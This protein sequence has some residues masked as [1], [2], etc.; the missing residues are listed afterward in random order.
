MGVPAG[1]LRLTAVEI[2]AMILHLPTVKAGAFMNG[3]KKHITAAFLSAAMLFSS[4]A[5]AME[6]RQ[7]DKMADQDRQ[8]FL[9][10]LPK[11]AETV[12]EQEGRSADA[13]KVHHLFN[14]IHPGDVMSFGEIELE[15]NLDNQRVRDA[16]KHIKNPDA[17]RLQVESALALTLSKNGVQITPD[18]VRSLMQLT[19]TFQPKFPPQTKDVKKKDA[20][21]KN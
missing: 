8:D 11:A 4:A 20:K 7:F 3:M 15:E 10:S 14:E 6:I 5:Q 13:L 1:V 19:G 18:F 9:N 16:Q 2:G 21:K 12:L 17:P